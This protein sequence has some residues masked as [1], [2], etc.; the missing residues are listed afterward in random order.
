MDL[1]LIKYDVTEAAISAMNS[2]YMPLKINGIDDKDGYA[3]V[4]KARKV[5]KGKRIEVEKKRKELNAD[6]LSW[7]K[8][9]NAKA[10]RIFDLLEPIENHLVAEQKAVDD[11]LARIE[12][13]RKAAEERKIQD[14]ITEIA[15]FGVVLPYGEIATMTDVEYD[16]K[17]AEVRA[18]WEA[19]QAKIAA[20][21]AEAERKTAEE[22]EARRLEDE[23]IAAER[24]ELEEMKKA[25][26]AELAKL[27]E[28]Q[29][30][31]AQ[32]LSDERA[33]IE[34]ERLRQAEEKAMVEA[35]DR[36]KREA[37][38]RAKHEKREAEEAK[39]R[40]AEAE[41]RR[42][43]LIPDK[44]KIIAYIVRFEELLNDF[45]HLADIEVAQIL[46]DALDRI[47]SELQQLREDVEDL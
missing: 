13:E 38:E 24:A 23:R 4:D 5:V 33:E 16:E 29:R 6:A 43:A 14:R 36:A 41:E 10:K 22:A 44:E 17:F 15:K 34:R 19:K 30:K 37:E 3:V 42:K 27:R 35:E 9:V 21:K 2:Q 40:E 45:P 20:E 25:Q 47:G 12:A 8:A 1:E 11:E 31:E 18:G 26:E 46:A 28:E 39:R 32:R 7:Q